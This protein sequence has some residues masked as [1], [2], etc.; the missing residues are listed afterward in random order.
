MLLE[1]SEAAPC[2]HETYVVRMRRVRCTAYLHTRVA[3]AAKTS[4]T[5]ALRNI[6]HCDPIRS[7]IVAIERTRVAVEAATFTLLSL[8]LLPRVHCYQ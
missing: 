7:S 1:S 3:D 8:M 6:H 5:M 4:P 2:M